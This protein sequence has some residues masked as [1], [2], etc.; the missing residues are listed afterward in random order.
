G[1]LGQPWPF[2]NEKAVRRAR[3]LGRAEPLAALGGVV[4][5]DALVVP[6]LQLPGLVL[7][8]PLELAQDPGGT[9]VRAAPGAPLLGAYPCQRRA[10]FDLRRPA[11]G[12][13]FAAR[14]VDFQGV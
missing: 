6:A 11:R 5:E 8:G 4:E 14:R 10:A 3:Q 9:G 12:T 7:A 1:N 13:G 2:V